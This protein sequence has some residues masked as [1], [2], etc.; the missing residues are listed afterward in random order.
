MLQVISSPKI[1]QFRGYN[2]GSEGLHQITVFL[3]KSKFSRNSSELLDLFHSGMRARQGLMKWSTSLNYCFQ[4]QFLECQVLTVY[5]RC[6]KLLQFRT[7]PI[8]IFAH[9]IKDFSTTGVVAI[10]PRPALTSLFL[11]VQQ[12]SISPNPEQLWIKSLRC[13]KLAFVCVRNRSSL[14]ISNE[15]SELILRNE[16]GV[17]TFFGRVV[18]Y[19]TNPRRERIAEWTPSNI[20]EL[21]MGNLKDLSGGEEFF[22]CSDPALHAGNEIVGGVKEFTQGMRVTPSNLPTPGPTSRALHCL[23]MVN[24]LIRASTG[25]WI[26]IASNVKKDHLLGREDDGMCFHCHSGNF[27]THFAAYVFR[28]SPSTL[29]DLLGFGRGTWGRALFLL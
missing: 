28:D 20:C 14:G 7:H 8:A 4:T 23:S 2:A 15:Q 27:L 10:L 12:L 6:P 18:P 21:F 17:K 13:P 26:G 3:L 25:D 1:T 22:I 24:V 29:Q 11:R 9:L 16:L 19:F 5:K